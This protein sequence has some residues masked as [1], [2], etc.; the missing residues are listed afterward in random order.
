MT[1]LLSVSPLLLF[2]CL[3]PS[4]LAAS[5]DPAHARNITIYHVNEKNYSAAP[6]NMNTVRM[7]TYPSPS[8]NA[9]VPNSRRSHSNLNP[10]IQQSSLKTTQADVNGD[11]YFDLRSRG[12]PLECGPLVNTSFWS[13]LDCD[14]PEVADPSRL[15]ITKLVME[16]DTRWGDYADC[17][18]DTATGEYVG[19]EGLLPGCVHVL[20]CCV[21]D[22]GY[23]H[24]VY[25]MVYTCMV[26]TCRV[27]T[28][29]C[30]TV[31]ILMY[32]APQ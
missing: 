8:A 6:V 23:L 19:R 29:W 1:L 30:T 21:Y 11:L 13:R 28:A 10:N 25:C 12:L 20:V 26:D 18:I 32:K 3:A 7:T 15:A 31:L 27:Y 22:G 2:L 9:L 14:N 4:S 17:N 5:I 24:G 16:V